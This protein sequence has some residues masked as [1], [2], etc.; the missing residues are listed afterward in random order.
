ME[1]VKGRKNMVRCVL[2]DSTGIVNAFFP[3]SEHLSTGNSVAIF[4]AEARVVREH[5]EVQIGPDGRIN[6]ARKEVSDVN[7]SFNASSKSWVPVD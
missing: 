7:E 2:G 5:I 4:G 6:R 1:V 3:E